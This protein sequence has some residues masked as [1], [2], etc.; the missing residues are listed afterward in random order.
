[1][2]MQF[3]IFNTVKATSRKCHINE[4]WVAETISRAFQTI[5]ACRKLDFSFQKPKVY[6]Y[7]SL[8]HPIGNFS[9]NNLSR[10]K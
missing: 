2:K 3:E 4:I 9:E 1:M 5:L 8:H 7:L 6:N 10:F